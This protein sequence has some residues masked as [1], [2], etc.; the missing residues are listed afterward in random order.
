M[1]GGTASSSDL[2]MAYEI[3]TYI[4]E[5]NYILLNGGRNKGIMEASAKGAF[6]SGGITIGIL[7]GTSLDETSDYIKI[8][9]LTGIGNAR[10]QINILSSHIVVTFKGGPGTVSEVAF[11]L[12]FGRKIIL[13][14]FYPGIFIDQYINKTVF[15]VKNPKEAIDKIKEILK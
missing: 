6:E 3:G 13:I 14:D 10:N 2:E 11:A 7:P 15:L 4:A 12:K 9:I 5:N 8:P 1:G